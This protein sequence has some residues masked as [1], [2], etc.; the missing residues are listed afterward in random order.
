MKIAKMINFARGLGHNYKTFMT[1]MLGKTP[2]PTFNQ[3][4]NALRGFYMR[5]DE[6]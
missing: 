6:E 3:F 1:V 5:E 2:Y 4:I